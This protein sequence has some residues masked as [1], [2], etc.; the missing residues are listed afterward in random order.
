MWPPR[1]RH[2]AFRNQ[3]TDPISYESCPEIIENRFRDAAENAGPDVCNLVGQ[4]VFQLSAPGFTGTG[5]RSSQ[6]ESRYRGSPVVR[7]F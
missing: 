6:P 3:K 7:R 1:E 2:F 5:N 4:V